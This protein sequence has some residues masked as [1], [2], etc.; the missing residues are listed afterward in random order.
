M[1]TVSAACMNI[2]TWPRLRNAAVCCSPAH[3][4]RLFSSRRGN[5]ANIFLD[6]K[7]QPRGSATGR[8]KIPG[9]HV[10][11]TDLKLPTRKPSPAAIARLERERRRQLVDGTQPRRDQKVSPATTIPGTDNSAGGGQKWP[12]LKRRTSSAFGGTALVN[13]SSDPPS[14]PTALENIEDL[15]GRKTVGIPKSHVMLTIGG[16]SKNVNGSDFY[17]IADNDLSQW[18]ASIK[19]STFVRAIATNAQSNMALITPSIVQKGRDMTTLE[20]TGS[21]HLTFSSSVASLAYAERFKR[22]HKLAQYKAKSK[23][24]LWQ[25][26]TP[27]ELR[28]ANP[29][30]D[31]LEDEV[32]LL[33]IAAG[34]QPVTVYHSRVAVPPW[35]QKVSK[36]VAGDGFGEQ[37]PVVILEVS[38]VAALDFVQHAIQEEGRR[39]GASWATV[40]LHALDANVL[41]A[42]APRERPEEEGTTEKGTELVEEHQ[43]QHQQEEVAEEDIVT[44]EDHCVAVDAKGSR[45]PIDLTAERRRQAA[46]RI[47][48]HMEGIVLK[49][50][51]VAFADES[52]AR[53]FHRVWNGRW[54]EG[55]MS[56]PSAARH[57]VRTQVIDW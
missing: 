5:G 48:R 45:P 20:P 29:T 37:P 25:S 51:L 43:H 14:G 17:R 4:S 18:N 1:F 26:E 42:M 32:A 56:N 27:P 34:A 53:R 3:T 24:G 23:T 44:E 28:G 12:L 39:I 47:A 46:A 36:L 13:T 19:K 33:S 8:N 49:R 2:S 40:A 30:T 9:S 35:A 15:G 16:L 54:L 55:E 21:Y 11:A 10:T 38:P 57:S 22:L 50:F 52:E 41:A 6:H 7:L 31:G